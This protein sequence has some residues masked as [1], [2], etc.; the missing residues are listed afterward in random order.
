MDTD[1]PHLLCSPDASRARGVLHVFL[2]G[3]GCTPTET[4]CTFYLSASLAQGLH[5]IALSYLWGNLS[6]SERNAACLAQGRQ[7]QLVAF[8]NDVVFGGNASGLVDCQG[9]NSVCERLADLLLF[10]VKSRQDEEGWE[11]FLENGEPKWEKIVFSGHSQG[12]GHVCLLAKHKR[13]AAAIFISGPQE[14]MPEDEEEESWLSGPFATSQLFAFAHDAEELTASLIRSCW[15]AIEPLHFSPALGSASHLA[16]FPSPSSSPADATG[17]RT[18]SSSVLPDP[19]R[20]D[21]GGR[22]NH[23][24]TISDA[25]TPIAAATSEPLYQPLWTHLFASATAQHPEATRS[26]L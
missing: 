8:H 6:D 4:P 20:G 3:T 7:A 10:L 14:L 11:K 24:S 26:S 15:A 12:S 23:N 1:S 25:N 21:F 18:F 2:C 17:R 19:A 5:T 9:G 16:P 22:P 13:L